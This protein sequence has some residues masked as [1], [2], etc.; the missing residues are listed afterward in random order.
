MSFRN[1][2]RGTLRLKLGARD[3]KPRPNPLLIL[4]QDSPECNTA[5]F[6]AHGVVSTVSSSKPRVASKVNHTACLPHIP[7][8]IRLRGEPRVVRRAV[9]SCYDDSFRVAYPATECIEPR[10]SL[11]VERATHAWG[12]QRTKLSS[13]AYPGRPCM[14]RRSSRVPRSRPHRT[15]IGAVQA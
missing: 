5:R 10:P 12:W 1:A 14:G 15:A 11:G 8:M 9:P 6:D 7:S 2:G 13:Y 3:C 4:L